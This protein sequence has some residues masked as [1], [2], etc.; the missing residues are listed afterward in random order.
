MKNVPTA[1]EIYKEYSDRIRGYIRCQIQNPED[2]ED[3][4]SEIFEKVVRGL[5]SYNPE[6][7]SLSTWIYTITKNRLTDYFRTRHISSELPEDILS[8][9]DP[10]A[11][12]Y[13]K[14][15]LDELAEALSS[16]SEQERDI[17]VLTYYEKYT[18]K[19]VCPMMDL[20]YGQVKGLRQ[21]ALI[22]LKEYL[23]ASGN[24]RLLSIH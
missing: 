5:D 12:I 1:E 8:E 6:K 24:G 22:K 18:L 9:E 2:A 23:I 19:E 11:E 4:H 13:E 17:I 16:L 15:T 20:T 10:F 21:K 3:L 7:A 14:E